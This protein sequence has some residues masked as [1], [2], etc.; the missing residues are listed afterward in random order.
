M[1]TQFVLDKP[2]TFVDVPVKATQRGFALPYPPVLRVNI[3]TG[4]PQ[5]KDKEWDG[6]L[7]PHPAAGEYGLATI[8]YRDAGKAGVTK[9]VTAFKELTFGEWLKALPAWRQVLEHADDWTSTHVL[10]KQAIASR[11]RLNVTTQV[12]AGTPTLSGNVVTVPII[13]TPAAI[14]PGSVAEAYEAEQP[15][16]VEV[17]VTEYVD[18]QGADSG[19]QVTTPRAQVTIEWDPADPQIANDLFHVPAADPG[20]VMDVEAREL[21]DATW[22]LIQKDGIPRFVIFY[23]HTST[24]KS[25]LPQVWCNS[26]DVLHCRID[27]GGFQEVYDVTGPI[28]AKEQN[29]VSVT[30]WIKGKTVRAMAD[31]RPAVIQLDEGNRIA[32]AKA[33]NILFPF[34]DSARRSYFDE[35]QAWMELRG[36]KMVILTMNGNTKGDDIGDYV[37]TQPLD[38]AF[39]SRFP[40]RKQFRYPEQGKLVDILTRRAPAGIALEDIEKIS[41]VAQELVALNKYV[42]NLRELIQ[43]LNFMGAGYSLYRALKWTVGGIYEDNGTADCDW[44]SFAA[45]MS[46][47]GVPME[48]TNP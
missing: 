47:K 24:G 1:T 16:Q 38:Q 31:P 4:K 42:P 40:I 19:L 2:R 15:N 32:D 25:E 43:C 37:G 27:C 5:A 26:N 35:A 9:R 34:F 18:A 13:T 46:G 12:R 36:A 28:M 23:G 7:V 20:F 8:E 10:V 29:G 48:T 30:E 44:A 11:V 41:S 6:H 3:A 45:V 21:L 14:T 17:A 22:A 33:M 39:I